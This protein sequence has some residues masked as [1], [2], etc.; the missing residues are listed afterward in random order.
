MS[1]LD[2]VNSLLQQEL[3]LLISHHIPLEGG[4]V[5]VTHVD[6]SPDLRF[7]NIFVSVLPEKFAGTVLSGLR[8][9]SGFLA[10][11]LRPRLK[12]KRMP[13][14]NWKLDTTETKAAEIDELFSL[15][16]EE[17]GDT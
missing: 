7:A 15:L 3:A 1:R 2:Q 13:S 5:T 17:E 8:K 12:M 6:C 4:L 14:F 9:K 10:Q 11:H 16:G